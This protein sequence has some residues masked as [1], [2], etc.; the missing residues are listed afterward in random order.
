MANHYETYEE[1][2][3]ARALNDLTELVVNVQEDL[4]ALTKRKQMEQEARDLEA[5]NQDIKLDIIEEYSADCLAAASKRRRVEVNSVYKYSIFEKKDDKLFL[6]P[7]C[8]ECKEILVD[9]GTERDPFFAGMHCC[10]AEVLRREPL[11]IEFCAPFGNAVMFDKLK[12][13]QIYRPQNKDKIMHLPRK[14]PKHDA[15]PFLMYDENNEVYSFYNVYNVQHRFSL[16]F[17]V[18]EQPRNAYALKLRKEIDACCAWGPMSSWEEAL[19][20][21]EVIKT[22]VEN[23]EPQANIEQKLSDLKAARRERMI[24]IADVLNG[25]EQS[26]Y[27]KEKVAAAS[28]GAVKKTQSAFYAKADWV[29]GTSTGGPGNRN[30][31]LSSANLNLLLDINVKKGFSCGR[32]QMEDCKMGCGQVM[33]IHNACEENKQL[34]YGQCIRWDNRSVVDMSKAETRNNVIPLVYIK[35]FNLPV[36]PAEKVA[37]EVLADPSN[38]KKKESLFENAATPNHTSYFDVNPD[39]TISVLENLSQVI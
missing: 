33:W 9:V 39:S 18:K 24:K 26:K 27:L 21:T 30:L 31:K 2:L 15:G 17:D 28:A 10:R 22:M 11:L 5:A 23:L 20:K 12:Q 4:V 32:Y 25:V 35:H 19:K 3:Q 16:I 6:A 7:R 14:C 1:T 29:K 36:E 37:A 34:L 38:K 13:Y 8:P